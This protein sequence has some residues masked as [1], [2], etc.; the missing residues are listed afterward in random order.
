MTPQQPPLAARK[1]EL[2]KALAH[3]VRVRILET[4][5][6]GE[7]SV[8]SLAIEMGTEPSNVSQQLAVLRNAGLVS[9]RKEG[10]TVF[11]A[12]RDPL[13]ADLLLAA[14]RLLLSGL[15]QADTLVA[16]LRQELS[17]S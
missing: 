9:S 16:D 12:V 1:A 15:L 14:K 4:L 11:Y 8:G 7:S 13:L 3:A 5:V 2:F 17:E 10:Q 6:N